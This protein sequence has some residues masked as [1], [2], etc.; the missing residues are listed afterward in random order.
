[1]FLKDKLAT[2]DIFAYDVF[3]KPGFNWA[4]V[5]VATEAKGSRFLQHFRV[6]EQLVLKGRLLKCKKSNKK[7]EP[8]KVIALVQKEDDLHQQKKKSAKPA[9]PKSQLSQPHYAFHSMATG[10]WDY[11]RHGKLL[12]DQKYQDHRQGTIIFGRTALVIYLESRT[13]AENEEDCNCRLDIPYGIIEH[14]LPWS[15]RQGQAP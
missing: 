11:D 3:K 7:A 12:F 2:F 6:R 10:V 13:Y 8:L 14:A 1:M 9:L 15:G 5:T 4:L